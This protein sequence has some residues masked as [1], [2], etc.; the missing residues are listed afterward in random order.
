MTRLRVKELREKEK[1]DLLKQLGEFKKELSQLRVAQQVSGN[2]AKLGKI[3]L[4]RK[5]VARVLTVLNQKEKENL[6]KFY[7]DKKWTPKNLRA[8]LTHKRRLAL[9]TQESRRRTRK[10]IRMAAKYPKRVFAVKI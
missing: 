9:T 5:N 1:T 3:R 2:A 6:R 4:M 10:Q 8:K 7:A